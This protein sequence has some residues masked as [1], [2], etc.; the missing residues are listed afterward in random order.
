MSEIVAS[1]AGDVQPEVI[2]EAHARQLVDQIND[3]FGR[4]VEKAAEL[5]KEQEDLNDLISMAY[6]GRAWVALGYASW[7]EMCH[8][9][10]DA[11]RVIRSVGERRERVQALI[12][13][14]LSTRAVGAVLGVHKDTVRRDVLATGANAPVAKAAAPLATVP[15]GTVATEPSVAPTSVGLD[16]KARTRATDVGRVDR[17]LQVAVL[18]GEGKTQAEI[19]AELGVSQRTISSDDRMVKSWQDSLDDEDLQRL[20]SG[21]MD[22]HE[23]AAKARFELVQPEGLRLEKA[24]RTGGSSLLDAARFV[25]NSVVLSDAWLD[26]R[27]ALSEQLASDSVKALQ[28]VSRWM[29]EELVWDDLTPERAIGLVEGLRDSAEWLTSAADALAELATASDVGA[30]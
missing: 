25:F 13:E 24:A 10:F 27:E 28:I 19:A 8:A 11:A 30:S 6:S 23:V 3:Q 15:P 16:G 4:A 29:A 18:R 17:G 21:E 5:Q 14:G 9:E 12:Q 26:E 1:T 2:S 7:D 20:R 22:R